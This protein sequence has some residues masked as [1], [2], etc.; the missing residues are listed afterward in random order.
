MAD[1]QKKIDFAIRL[2][3]SIPTDEGPMEICYYCQR[4]CL[5]SGRPLIS[6]LEV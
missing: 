3:Q 2:L 4:L 1:L 6:S 5:K